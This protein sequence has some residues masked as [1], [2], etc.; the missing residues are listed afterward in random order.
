MSVSTGG[1]TGPGGA[2][3][4][5]DGPSLEEGTQ[6]ETHDDGWYSVKYYPAAGEACAYRTPTRDRAP[7]REEE[8]EARPMTPE[9]RR[10]NLARAARRAKSEVRRR[11]VEFRLVLMWTLTYG[12]REDYDGPRA[13]GSDAS[14]E[15][16]GVAR[17]AGDPGSPTSERSECGRVVDGLCECG[18]PYGLAGLGRAMK[19]AAA[20]V[21]RLRAAYFRGRRFPYVLVPEFHKDGHVHVHMAVAEFI[22]W[23]LFG[24]VWGHGYVAFTDFRSRKKGEKR[25]AAG[26]RSAGYLTKYV[27]KMFDEELGEAAAHRHRYEVAQGFEPTSTIA[28]GFRSRHAALDFLVDA[29]GVKVDYVKWS[30]DVDPDGVQWAWASVDVLEV[31]QAVSR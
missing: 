17:S 4:A 2:P 31:R 22:P 23:D 21:K 7:S 29:Y 24:R 9:R 27:T 12:E 8:P 28:G 3:G 25:G 13:N 19:D 14:N 26:K 15:R 20:F 11:C 6:L 16:D 5:P 10:E 1:D 18:R 30:E